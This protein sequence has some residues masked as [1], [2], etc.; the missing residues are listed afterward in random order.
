[1]NATAMFPLPVGMHVGFVIVCT[2]ILAVGFIKKKYLYRILLEADIMLSMLVYAAKNSTFTMILGIAET[3]LFIA[4]AVMR[5]IELGMAEKNAEMFEYVPENEPE[6]KVEVTID[7]S[8]NETGY[9]ELNAKLD[10]YIKEFND[11]SHS[12]KDDFE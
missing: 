11:S 7:K 9:E 12:D 4:S 6:N 2:V 8:T 10:M 3:A 1:M 5:G